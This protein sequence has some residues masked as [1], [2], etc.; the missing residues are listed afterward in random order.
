MRY[1]VFEQAAVEA[2]IGAKEIDAEIERLKARKEVLETLMRQL[3]MALPMLG[4][5]TEE[6]KPETTGEEPA[7]GP[8]SRKE[9]L[10]NGKAQLDEWSSFI[11]A[12]TTPPIPITEPPYVADYRPASNLLSLRVAGL[13]SQPPA[14]PRGLR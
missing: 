1:N 6:S 2:T 3:S 9:G 5:E 14:G 11:S 10:P 7:S 4:E 8:A 12:S 13:P